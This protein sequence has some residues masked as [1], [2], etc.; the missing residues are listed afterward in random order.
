MDSIDIKTFDSLPK[1]PLISDQP[2]AHFDKLLSAHKISA[3]EYAQIKKLLSRSPTLSELGVF[4]AMWSEHCSY[5]SS[6]VHLGRFPTTGKEVVLGPGEN[7]GVV[8]LSG[9]LCAVFKM[10]SHN[11]PSYIEPFQGAATG[12]GGILR[13]VFCMGARPVANLNCL[14]FGERDHKKTNWLMTNVVKGIGDYGNCV[15][16]PTVGGS[17]SFDA[18]Y[19]G[20]CLVNAMTVGLIHE[21][22]IFKGFA[23]GIGNLVI[24]VGS[25]TG[26]D[27]IHGATMASDSFASSTELERGA[28][29]VGD[30]FMEKLLLEATLEVLEKDLVIGIQDMGAA[31]LTSSAFEMADR[32]GSGLFLDL[33]KVPQRAQAMSAYEL[34]LSE[35]QER[36]LMVIRPEKWP[37][38]SAVLTKWQLHFAIIGEVT[39]SGKMQAVFNGVVELDVSIAPLAASAPKYNRPLQLPVARVAQDK[40]FN[41]TCI[42]KI[43][44]LGISA[45]L[46][47]ILARDGS[48]SGIYE[49]YDHHIGTSTV[50]GPETGGAAVQWIRTDFQDPAEPWLGLLSAAGCNEKYCRIDPKQ[51]AA[52]A[53]VKTARMISAAGGTPIAV[54]DCLNYGN[55]ESPDVMGQFS[56]GVDGISEACRALGTPVVS[57]NV[58]LYNETDGKS[59]AP[60]PMIGMVGK[61][62]DV[63][64]A[65]PAIITKESEILILFPKGSSGTFGGALVAQTFGFD[66]TAGSIPKIDYPA[67]VQ[68][69]NFLR[70]ASAQGWLL[71]ARDVGAGGIL[72]TAFKM[73]EAGNL[74]LDIGYEPAEPES[75]F[76]SERSASYLLNV[77]QTTRKELEKAAARLIDFEL[78]LLGKAKKAETQASKLNLNFENC[79]RGYHGFFPN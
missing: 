64:K 46:E 41:H 28:V 35:S 34:L 36:M 7:A 50:F 65:V 1:A 4:S 63:R 22:R 55:P 60:T 14:R 5:K 2:G 30:P 69:M 32:A 70:E 73:C 38:L 56:E 51:G 3:S 27:G 77:D 25:A 48:K 57:G 19:N 62:T 58:S 74:T 40:D 10:E 6:R 24:Y 31:G 66:L 13:D 18:S 12:V 29:Q 76:F 11:H 33:T 37:A 16:I 8:R 47:K 54:T 79:R 59:I 23:S 75:F 71:A 67:E 61:I 53:V 9:K 39:D 42:L 52:A 49:Q 68:A 20:N 15:G 44:A 45:V 78:I 43:R 72:T 21:D 26:R 17:V